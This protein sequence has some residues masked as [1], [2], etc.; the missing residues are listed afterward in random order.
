MIEGVPALGPTGSLPTGR[1]VTPV[2]LHYASADRK[3]SP[4]R[5]EPYDGPGLRTFRPVPAGPYC[6]AT[7]ASI[8]ATCPSTCR[9]KRAGCY[10]RAGFTRKA[11]DKL[12]EAARGIDPERV[13]DVEVGLIDRA[14]GVD[15]VGRGAPIPQDGA[16]GGRDLRMHIGGDVPSLAAAQRLAGAAKR[17]MERGGGRVWT[18]THRWRPVARYAFGAISVLASV[19]T[20]ADARAADL[21]GF[22][23]AMVVHAF[24]DDRAFRVDGLRLK[25]IPCPAETRGTDKVTCVTCRLCLDDGA[26]RRRG[27]AI[28]FSLHG[29]QREHVQLPVLPTRAA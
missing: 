4:V 22:V 3:L 11:S 16:R 25:V 23:P 10:V 29:L 7:Y 8:E 26:L 14:F 24:P 6:S 5:Q 28:G 17:W 13:A 19:E 15:G 21:R 18:Y 27:A 12:D 20:V 1:I 9:F 2:R